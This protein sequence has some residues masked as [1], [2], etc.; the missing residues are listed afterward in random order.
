M[1]HTDLKV[2]SCTKLAVN[3]EADKWRDKVLSMQINGVNANAE[4]LVALERERRQCADN[5]IVNYVNRVSTKINAIKA[6]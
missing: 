5:K 4:N 6:K 1:E 2:L 3:A